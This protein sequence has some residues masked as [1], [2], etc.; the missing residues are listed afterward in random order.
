M[1]FLARFWLLTCLT[2]LGARSVSVAALS[3][4]DLPL[5]LQAYWDLVTR[6][7]QTVRD[8]ADASD[9]EIRQALDTLAAEWESARAVQLEDGQVIPV[10]PSFLVD[11]LKDN[12]P[13]LDV[14]DGVLTTLLDAHAQAPQAV[15]GP[16]DVAPLQ[17]ILRRPEFQWPEAQASQTP[18]WLQTLWDKIFDFLERLSLGVQN[19]VYYGRL[20]LIIAGVLIFIF[21][22]F[23]VIR[24]FSRNLV[25]DSQLTE[26]E[27]IAEGLLTAKTA[28]QRAQSLSDHGDYRTAVRYLYLSSLLILDEQGLLR[29]DRSRTNRE[30]LRS[31]AAKPEIEKP[32]HDVIDVFDRVWYGFEPVDDAAYQSYVEHVEELRER[33]E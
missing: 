27:Q 18:S 8:L 12:S 25:R 1:R 14:L 28:L 13:D 15:F 31:V 16:Q 6:S 2:L 11:L 22:L 32:L 26:E 30:Y 20:P 9:T 17:E 19:T 4:V 21:S 10:E 3:Q 23:F 7:R 33:K 24:N 29:Y 5:S